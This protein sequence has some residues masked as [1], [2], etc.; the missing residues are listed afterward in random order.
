MNILIVDDEI[1]ARSYLKNIINSN[2]QQAVTIQ[3]ANSV[4]D[5]VKLLNNNRFEIV[6]LDIEMPNENGFALFDYF[7]NPDFEVIFCTAYSEFAISAFK[8]SAIDYILKPARVED[9]TQAIDRVLKKQGQNQFSNRI[10]V[11]KDHLK[12]EKSQK[13]ALPANDGISFVNVKDIQY[14]E[15]DGSYTKVYTLSNMYMVSKK[16]KEFE[17]LLQNDNRFFRVHR[18]YIINLNKIVKYN[19][20]EGVSLEIKTLDTIPVGREKKHD[21][22]NIIKNISLS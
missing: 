11:L 17:T 16:I 9:V 19:R 3:E 8:F 6:F 7:E 21:F 18:S 12:N 14:F 1:D 5:A 10:E 22:E 2:Y 4:S 15:A 13:I 20:T